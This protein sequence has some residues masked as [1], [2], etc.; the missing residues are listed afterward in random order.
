M[1]PGDIFIFLVIHVLVAATGLT[2]FMALRKKMKKENATNETV[3]A[4]FV[5][6]AIYG[7]LYHRLSSKLRIQ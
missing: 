1:N 4:L 2:F 5:I 3:V 7:G 6:F